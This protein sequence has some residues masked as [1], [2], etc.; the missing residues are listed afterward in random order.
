MTKVKKE[1]VKQENGD[2]AASNGDTTEKKK[3]KNTKI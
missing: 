1:A 3:G 2:K